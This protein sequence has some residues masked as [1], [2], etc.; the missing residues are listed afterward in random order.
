[1]AGQV[2]NIR[3][4]KETAAL[5]AL[6]ARPTEINPKAGY[7]IVEVGLAKSSNARKLYNTSV[8]LKVPLSDLLSIPGIAASLPTSAPATP[9]SL[10]N[11]GGSLK[12]S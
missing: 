9:G 7:V 12:I 4:I 1:M 6:V 3:K 5:S 8:Q 2:V 10:W 11:D